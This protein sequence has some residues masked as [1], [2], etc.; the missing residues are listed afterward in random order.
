[1]GLH[2]PYW[3]AVKDHVAESRLFGPGLQ[4]QRWDMSGGRFEIE[5]YPDREKLTKKYSW[6]IPDPDSIEFVKRWSQ[7]GLIDPM[8]GTGYWA[9]ILRQEGVDIVTYD[10]HPGSNPWHRTN[11]L[12]V[13]VRK[14]AAA[15]SVPKHPDRTLLL[16]WPPYDDSAGNRALAAYRG[17]RV[18]YMGEGSGGCTGNDALHR[19]LGRDWEEIDEHIPVQ[20]EG[21]HDRITVYQRCP[22][23]KNNRAVRARGGLS[24]VGGVRG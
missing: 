23:G 4:V 7:G 5:G 17:E 22:S 8:A 6:T 13:P 24:Q 15:T 2:N 20:W 3:D 19:R 10:K 14:L 11:D 1:V 9:Y 16:A 12:H 18:I 21:L